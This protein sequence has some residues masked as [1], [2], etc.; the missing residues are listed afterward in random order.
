MDSKVTGGSLECREYCVQ[1]SE[2]RGDIFC[3]TREDLLSL[4]PQTPLCHYAVYDANNGDCT[5]YDDQASTQTGSDTIIWKDC[6][7]SF[8]YLNSSSLH[9]DHRVRSLY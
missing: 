1:V 6:R 8:Y 2:S 5:L 9:M 3:S 4:H 7:K